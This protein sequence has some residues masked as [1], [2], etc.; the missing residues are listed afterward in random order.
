MKKKLSLVL[1]SLLISSS[2]FAL[3]GISSDKKTGT[4]VESSGGKTRSHSKSI[5]ESTGKSKTQTKDKATTLSKSKS[6]SKTISKNKGYSLTHSG[7][8]AVNLDLLPIIQNKIGE[9][10]PRSTQVKF[11]RNIIISDLGFNGILNDGVTSPQLYSYYTDLANTGSD[12]NEWGRGTAK[13]LKKVIISVYMMSD[14]IS[15]VAMRLKNDKTLN[16]YNLNEKINEKIQK[17]VKYVL[18]KYRNGFYSMKGKCYFSSPKAWS[19]DN[20]KYVL[21][22]DSGGRPILQQ[23]NFVIFGKG[24]VNG[25]SLSM[26]LSLGKTLSEGVQL[27]LADAKN[28]SN[29]FAARSALSIIKS[30]GKTK[31]TTEALS[32]TLNT[33]VKESSEKN[34]NE[35]LSAN[36]IK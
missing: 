20:R 27:A 6:W 23:G 33:I 4:S 35:T 3:P 17:A 5:G 7:T 21:E 30:K 32:K 34:I 18:E 9:M 13:H 28:R 24:L 10:F 1:I 29:A 11:S 26:N 15:E 22:L 25:R 36:P 16:A 12:V 14:I 2:A 8:L 31:Q 19:C